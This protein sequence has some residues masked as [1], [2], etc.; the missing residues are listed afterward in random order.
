MRRDEIKAWV[1]THRDQ[2]PTTVAGLSLFP[3][4]FRAMIVNSLAPEL[5]SAIWC[6]HLETFVG[7]N[8]TLSPEQQEFVAQSAER[9][10]T[11]LSGPAPNATIVEWEARMAR[12]F[13]RAEAAQIFGMVG[14]PEPPEGLPLPLGAKPSPV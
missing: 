10:P 12:L 9:I 8:S 13:S 14:P 2:L 7:G 1:E 4:P 5:R 3:I 6:E 11:L